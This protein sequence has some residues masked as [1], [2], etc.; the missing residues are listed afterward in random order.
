MVT[1]SLKCDFT[2]IKDYLFLHSY[3]R[4]TGNKGSAHCQVICN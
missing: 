3:E 2:I 1:I 4:K